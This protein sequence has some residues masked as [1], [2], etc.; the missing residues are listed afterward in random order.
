MGSHTSC[1]EDWEI[2]D[3]TEGISPFSGPQ[4]REE[5]RRE[6]RKVIYVCRG[7]RSRGDPRKRETARD[8]FEQGRR[9]L[10]QDDGPVALGREVC[11]SEG[12]KKVGLTVKETSSICV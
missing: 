7:W 6:K 4:E 1:D 5:D 8:L 2:T 3:S 12:C 9:S 10:E 11:V